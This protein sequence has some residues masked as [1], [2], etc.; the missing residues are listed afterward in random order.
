MMQRNGLFFLFLAILSWI[1]VQIWMTY[2]PPAVQP[3]EIAPVIQPSPSSTITITPT[4]TPTDTPTP[5][6]TPAPAVLIGAGDI[7]VCGL[8]GASRTA[9]LLA[10]LINQYPQAEIFTAGDNAQVMGL[11]QEYMDCFSPTWGRFWDR[12]HPSPGNHDWFTESG[13]DYFTYFGEAAGEAGN[14]YYSYDL[15]EWHIVSLN[16][17]CDAAGCEE[18]SAQV[19]WLRADLQQNQARCTLLYWHHPLW[20]S[21]TVPISPAGQAFWRIASEYGAEIVVNGHDHYYERFAPLDQ[22]GNVNFE[23][24]IRPFIVGTGGAW[25]FELDEPL[26]ITEAR[27]NT[28]FGV[29]KFLLYPDR[30]EWEY[31]AADGSPFTDSGTGTCH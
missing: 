26:A 22:D 4:S 7:S 12:I 18:G 11:M 28:S 29:I 13:R 8:D 15:G 25:L 16:S 5:V 20:S 2:F 14:G 19:E 23:T 6:P 27:D 21:G 24:G 31:V 17:N 30:Y 3:I 10:R 9:A 1:A